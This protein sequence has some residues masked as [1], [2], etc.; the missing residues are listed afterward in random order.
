[1]A[2]GRRRKRRQDSLR[3]AT[4]K[5]PRTGDHV[6]WER[7]N[8]VLE[9]KG[10]DRFAETACEKC[11]TPGMGRPG[12]VPGVYFRMRLI[13][14][15]EGL[16]SEHGIAWRRADSLSLHE[17]SG[18]ADR[19]RAGLFDGLAHTVADRSGNEPGSVMR[20]CSRSSN[21]QRVG[22][23][24]GTQNCGHHF[25]TSSRATSPRSTSLPACTSTIQQSARSIRRLRIALSRA[26][27]I[28]GVSHG[29]L[30]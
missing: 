16:D 25:T 7:V 14:Y 26:V 20:D 9:K 21:T 12:V 28:T 27:I 30:S 24:E 15:C 19:D 8:R 17:F 13:V 5:L 2:L 22:Q 10:F 3:I 29:T 18:C 23:V 6:I 11:S 1:M 4:Q